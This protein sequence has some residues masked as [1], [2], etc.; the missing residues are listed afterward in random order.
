MVDNLCKRFGKPC[1]KEFCSMH[2]PIIDKYSDCQDYLTILKLTPSQV[3]Y[4]MNILGSV[5]NC[6]FADEEYMKMS[7][8]I[9]RLIK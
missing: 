2:S 7:L 4:L 1:I 3:E 5:I 9:A 8:E 6:E